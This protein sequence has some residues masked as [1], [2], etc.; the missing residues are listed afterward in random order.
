MNEREYPWADENPSFE[1]EEYR[2]MEN[3]FEH[4]AEENED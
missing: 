2:E 3:D 1:H 4:Y